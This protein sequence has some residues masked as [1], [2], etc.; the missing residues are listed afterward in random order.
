MNWTITYWLVAAA[1]AAVAA[2]LFVRVKAVV[3]EA[4]R[5]VASRCALAVFAVF[6]AVCTAEAQK[7]K[8]GVD[9]PAGGVMAKRAAMPMRAAGAEKKSGTTR[10]GIAYETPHVV[11][12]Q[13]VARMWS[14]E[15]VATNE[16]FGYSGSCAN[17]VEET[18]WSARGGCEMDCAVE[19]GGGFAFPLGTNLLTRVRALSGGTVCAF[20]PPQS[21]QEICAARRY[22]HFVPGSSRFWHADADSG[23]KLLTWE[24]ISD[25]RDGTEPYSV[26]LELRASGDF[27]MRRGLVET[28]CRRI[29]PDDWDGDGLANELDPEPTT[30]RE[31][32]YFGTCT[33]WYNAVCGRV[34][35][36]GCDDDGEVAITWR[37]GVNANAYYWLEFAVGGAE[38]TATVRVTCDGPSNLGDMIVIARTNEV[39]RVPMLVGAQY[40]VVS[41]APFTSFVP[42]DFR[43]RF[44][45]V[46]NMWGP[47]GYGMQGSFPLRFDLTP[48]GDGGSHY[49]FSTWPINIGATIGE[50]WNS[51]C[52]C[53]ADEGGLSWDCSPSCHCV[54]G[55]NVWGFATWEGYNG[56]FGKYIGCPCLA[57]AYGDVSLRLDMPH[58]IFTNDD[59]GAEDSDIVELTAGV[60]ETNETNLEGVD[61]GRA[62]LDLDGDVGVNVWTSRDRSERVTFPVVW[63]LADHATTNL[64]V[65]GAR[66]MPPGAN[67]FTLD[68]IGKDGSILGSTNAEFAIYCPI[69]N[70]INNYLYDNG[71]LC[72]PCAIVTGKNACFEIEF[73]EGIEPS[74]EEIVWSIAEETRAS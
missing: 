57:K 12:A 26:Q 14:V 40:R 34:L 45:Y 23:A 74:P 35:Q 44:D 48:P 51:C 24:G 60:A 13:D 38:A 46:P 18:D 10:G 62:W 3:R 8:R 58:I 54:V 20:A 52:L 68:W 16:T 21:R 1:G 11:S 5:R 43:A 30:R 59:G 49:G 63:D 37:D 27:V 42:S 36:A 50:I 29:N 67:R 22:A 2:L 64:Y 73:G 7:Q 9:A 41:T 66:N 4:A 65:E 15:S 56:R 32:L 61:I 31:E 69:A 70:V 39:C 19:F 6:A 71:N 53:A 47:E 33:N 55:H 17:V 25:S 72:N 28:V